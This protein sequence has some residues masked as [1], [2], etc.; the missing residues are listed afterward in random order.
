MLIARLDPVTGKLIQNSGV[1]ITDTNNLSTPGSITT[2]VG[3]GS[4][5]VLTL[6][7]GAA[8]TAAAANTVQLRAPADI[9][10]AYDLLLPTTAG[11]CGCGRRNRQHGRP[12][13][14]QYCRAHGRRYPEHRHYIDG[15]PAGRYRAVG[16]CRVDLHGRECLARREWR[17]ELR[18]CAGGT[19]QAVYNASGATPGI[20]VGAAGLDSATSPR[21]PKPFGSAAM[22]AVHRPCRPTTTRR[23]PPG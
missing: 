19:L 15:L 23:P 16:N 8:P 2:G 18:Q 13:A 22:S 20:T 7:E 4:A 1:T 12:R 9:T 17:M 10:G 11:P 3:S 6:T 14:A 21:L 5:G